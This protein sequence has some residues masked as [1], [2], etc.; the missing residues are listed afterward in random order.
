[1]FDVP[2]RSAPAGPAERRSASPQ[3]WR[4]FAAAL[5][6]LDFGLILVGEGAQVLHVNA[7]AAAEL[8]PQHPLQLL[9]RELRARL[10]RDV[11]PLRAALD[12]AQRGLRRLFT[13]GTGA[14]SVVVSVVPLSPFEGERSGS[15]TATLLMLG[16]RR[17]VGELAVQGYAR[18]HGLTSSETR[19][20]AALCRGAR[21]VQIAI[22]HDVALSTVR[23]QIGSIRA[24]TG[25]AGIREL[26]QQVAALPPL[27]TVLRPGNGSDDWLSE[28]AEVD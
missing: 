20:L 1:M 6:E 18:A 28:P 25:A 12:G 19:V 17:A 9:G 5:D 13:L 16:R 26:V 4:W 23:T 2:S 8:G 24:K 7:A 10:P 21:P 22:E 15:D 11:A 27:L 3:L 14:D